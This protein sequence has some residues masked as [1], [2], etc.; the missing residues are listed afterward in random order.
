MEILNQ[1]N[2]MTEQQAKHARKLNQA[3]KDAMEVLPESYILHELSNDLDELKRTEDLTRA[4][5]A[6]YED[7]SGLVTMAD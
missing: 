6:Q 5:K 3:V 7:D 2:A 1:P 4:K